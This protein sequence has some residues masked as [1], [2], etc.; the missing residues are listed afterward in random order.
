M[1]DKTEKYYDG[2]IEVEIK[3]N[4]GVVCKA[5]TFQFAL[6]DEDCLTGKLLVMSWAV[7]L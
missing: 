3:L 2:I 4:D 6:I 1:G 7:Y 5:K